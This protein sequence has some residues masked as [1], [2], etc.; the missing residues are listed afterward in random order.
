MSTYLFDNK[1]HEA[2]QQVYPLKVT[3]RSFESRRYSADLEYILYI[4]K[5]CTAIESRILNWTSVAY[6]IY[7]YIPVDLSIPPLQIARV[8]VMLTTLLTSTCTHL[9]ISVKY[10]SSL[11]IRVIELI[12]LNFFKKWLVK[13]NVKYR[14]TD[15]LSLWY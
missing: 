10:F 14:R 9:S 5:N 1:S 13:S 7:K 12:F 11:V 3:D 15:A 2:I 8:A 6:I 4:Y